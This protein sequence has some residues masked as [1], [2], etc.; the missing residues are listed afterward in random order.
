M[1]ESL[2]TA[3]AFLSRDYLESQLI[4]SYKVDHSVKLEYD[5]KGDQKFVRA[6][7]IGYHHA[8]VNLG[9]NGVVGQATASLNSLW[10]GEHSAEASWYSL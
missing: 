9:F 3:K 10:T 4:L 7:H 1:D 5:L 6:Q 8:I 2:A